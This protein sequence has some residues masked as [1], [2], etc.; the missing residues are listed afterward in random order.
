M[1][2]LNFEWRREEGSVNVD[3]WGM[4]ESDLGEI[5]KVIFCGLKFKELSCVWNLG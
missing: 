1:G 5:L 2:F 3:R 4:I